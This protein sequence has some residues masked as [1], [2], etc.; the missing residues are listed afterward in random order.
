MFGN[1]AQTQKQ[2][3][4]IT[5]ENDEATVLNCV[6][7][8]CVQFQSSQIILNNFEKTKKNADIQIIIEVVLKIGERSPSIEATPS[9][10]NLLQ[11]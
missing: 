6:K 11:D 9:L 5:D 8:I 1:P 7:E 10:C 4:M 2:T 3:K